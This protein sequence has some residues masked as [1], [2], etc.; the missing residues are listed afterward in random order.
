[1]S[2]NSVDALQKHMLRHFEDSPTAGSPSLKKSSKFSLCK[3]GGSVQRSLVREGVSASGAQVVG[4]KG[5]LEG[6][7][8]E[9]EAASLPA[10]GRKGRMG[11]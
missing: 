7:G 8:E 5:E 3:G 4:V 10:K 2:F 6:G 9:R 1:M 11:S